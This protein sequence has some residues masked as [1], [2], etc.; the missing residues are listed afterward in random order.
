MSLR[1]FDSEA[2]R[3]RFKRRYVW[4]FWSFCAGAVVGVLIVASMS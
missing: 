2:G 3:A 1:Y 4:A